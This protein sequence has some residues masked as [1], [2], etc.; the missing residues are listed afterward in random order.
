MHEQTLVLLQQCS[1]ASEA[2]CVQFAST[3]EHVIDVL[4]Q[5][6]QQASYKGMKCST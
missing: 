1:C 3:G 2:R 5:I 6:L 4:Q